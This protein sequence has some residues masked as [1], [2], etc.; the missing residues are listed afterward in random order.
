MTLEQIK[1][2]VLSGKIV[3]WKNN[4]YT[5]SVSNRNEWYIVC[6]LNDNVTRLVYKD[7]GNLID[8]E[9]DFYTNH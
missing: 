7:S 9:D 1:S 3:Y 8:K 4:S 5:V 6:D 2:T